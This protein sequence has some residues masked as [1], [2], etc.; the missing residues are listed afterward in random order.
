MRDGRCVQCEQ[1][2]P[3]GPGQIVMGGPVAPKPI[4]APG[5]AVAGG[6]APGRAVVGAEPVMLAVEPSPVG[7]STMRQAW[8]NVR[9]PGS[10]PQAKAPAD[11]SIMPTSFSPVAPQ[12]SGRPHI[13]E[14]LF[15]VDAIG[16]RSRRE[17]ERRAREKHASIAYGQNE[18][19][20]TDLPASMV[21]SK[22]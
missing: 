8:A 15:G 10:N 14:H 4:G 17:N 12:T 6:D 21:Y 9:R 18:A 2:I 5:R 22:R 20:V 3:I 1:A 19:K 7:R 16:S 13:L 11:P